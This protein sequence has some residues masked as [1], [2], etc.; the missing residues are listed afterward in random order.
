MTPD[1]YLEKVRAGKLSKPARCRICGKGESLSWHGTYHRSLITLA[2][3]LTIPIKRLYCR[4]CQ[5]TFALL[6]S[7]VVKFH[8]YARAA[9]MTALLALRSRTFEAVADL[10]MEQGGHYVSP[11]TFYFWRHKFS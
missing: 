11:L 6:P 4:L 9:I 8:R 3:T 10:F 7:F 5:H 1:C 2:R